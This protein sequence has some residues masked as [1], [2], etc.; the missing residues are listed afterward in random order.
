MSIEKD[1]L[2][3]LRGVFYSLYGSLNFIEGMYFGKYSTGC[4]EL[5]HVD[6]A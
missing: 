2:S 4:K 5:S 3:S 6:T 1:I